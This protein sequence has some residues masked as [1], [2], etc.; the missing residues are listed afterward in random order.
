MVA[1]VPTRFSVPH[2]ATAYCGKS[3]PAAALPAWM[4]AAGVAVG[5]L[6]EIPNSKLSAASDTRVQNCAVFAYSGI[7]VRRPTSEIFS[8]I[9][10]GHE[11]SMDNGVYSFGPKG[12]GLMADH[13]EWGVRNTPTVN[14]ASASEGPPRVNMYQAD[15]KPSSRHQYDRIY[16]SATANRFV[17]LGGDGLGVLAGSGL[18]VSSDRYN[19][20]MYDPDAD[21]WDA[22]ILNTEFDG[23]TYGYGLAVDHV[24]GEIYTNGMKKFNPVTKAWASAVTSNGGPAVGIRFPTVVAH[25]LGYALCLMFGNGYSAGSGTELNASK[26]NLATGARSAVTFNPSQGYTDF[27]AD[28]AAAGNLNVLTL[29][30]DYDD[31]NGNFITYRGT[32]GQ[33]NRIYRIIPHGEG[34]WDIE[35]VVLAAGSVTMT[36]QGDIGPCGRVKYIPALKGFVFWPMGGKSSTPRYTDAP[37]YFLKTA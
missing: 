24:T 21:A 33:E 7:S 5:K 26:I 19:I 16:F 22:P 8:L 29:G 18:P 3:A 4:T 36:T 12:V 2:A 28:A 23:G 17:V 31:V 15:G 37:M 20:Y 13:P 30:L 34:N 11:D 27:L 32:A 25:D 6:V 14:P 9:A 35:R 1:A 10:G